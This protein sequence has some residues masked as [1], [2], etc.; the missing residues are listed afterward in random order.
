MTLYR[1]EET[2]RTRR[3]GDV[4]ARSPPKNDSDRAQDVRAGCLGQPHIETGA[5]PPNPTLYNLLN[6]S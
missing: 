4:E 3:G 1:K 6:Q 5:R 2:P